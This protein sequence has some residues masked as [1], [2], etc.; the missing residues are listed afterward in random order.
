MNIDV[1]AGMW[2]DVWICALAALTAPAAARGE[3]PKASGRGF[4]THN[5]EEFRLYGYGAAYIPPRDQREAALVVANGFDHTPQ[6]A[7]KI[8]ISGS[9]G[10]SISEHSERAL[11]YTDVALVERGSGAKHE[12]N[13]PRLKPLVVLSALAD[14]SGRLD[15]GGLYD[16]N[17]RCLVSGDEE[18]GECGGCGLPALSLAV[19]DMN[20]DGRLDLVVGT[21]PLEKDDDRNA[22]TVV[23]AC[24]FSTVD[25]AV[26]SAIEA[27][28]A[29]T[30]MDVGPLVDAL[31]SS[32]DEAPLD[33]EDSPTLGL[34][35]FPF[36][37]PP[38]AALMGRRDEVLASFDP[39]FTIGDEVLSSFD[40]ALYT[41]SH[42]P[43][44]LAPER[45]CYEPLCHDPRCPT[46]PEAQGALASR[47]KGKIRIYLQGENGEFR[48]DRELRAKSPAAIRLGDLDGDGS[49]DILAAG[50][51]V[52]IVL[53]PRGKEVRAPVPSLTGGAYSQGID[54]L[55]R[56]TGLVVAV[57]EGAATHEN[58]NCFQ[59]VRVWSYACPGGR[60][61]LQRMD[62]ETAAKLDVCGVP[63]DLR[64]TRV[65]DE[66]DVE[67]VVGRMT[68]RTCESQTLGVCI[69][70][71]LVALG[72]PGFTESRLLNSS[73]G[74]AMTARLEPFV[75]PSPPPPESEEKA[76]FVHAGS[77]EQEREECRLAADL[78][79]SCRV[80]LRPTISLG[81]PGEL[82][83]VTEV[84]VT[85]P[86]SE[87]EVVPS[88]HV[89]GDR[90][91][92]VGA[93]G[94]RCL[95]VR[96]SEVAAPSLFVTSASPVMGSGAN[97]IAKPRLDPRQSRIRD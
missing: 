95:H 2:L 97:Q 48:F 28:V 94:E 45:A 86:L 17:G 63:S 78:A 5:T 79:E 69:G 60:C 37:S 83:F 12:E 49:L 39:L 75:P 10:Y 36:S 51:G 68:E 64:F 20:G 56:K 9:T 54:F 41:T 29:L 11:Y 72:G 88:R 76:C 66:G 23:D 87:Q 73:M 58:L 25:A 70:A 91:L 82:S 8:P 90:H 77:D 31:S 67:L 32:A 43:A 61:D 1:V 62:E 80:L 7:T 21:I 89:V 34:F 4:S 46:S 3:C 50:F 92:T 19:G 22:T 74:K 55:R 14:E 65:R 57:T 96:W 33:R 42:A 59:S 26:S 16:W 84:E 13:E 44:S 27:V 30:K 38:R 85:A 53:D 15:T 71:P 52:D 47:K 81:L 93:T 35:A 18:L 24:I 6:Y 40:P